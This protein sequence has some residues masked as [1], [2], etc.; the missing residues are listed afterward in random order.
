MGHNSILEK[1]SGLYEALY[2]SAGTD[3]EMSKLTV[4]MDRLI[5]CRGEADVRKV[6]ADQIKYASKRMKFGKTDVSGGYSS[7]VFRHAPPILLKN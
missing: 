1:F 6:T 7:D 2:N 5:D 3:E 4:Q